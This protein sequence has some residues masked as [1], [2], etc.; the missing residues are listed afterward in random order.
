[1]ADDLDE[2]F[3][4]SEEFIPEPR[5]QELSDESDNDANDEPLENLDDRLPQKRKAIDS[6]TQAQERK[7]HKR[8]NITEILK[9]RKSE[10]AK[11]SYAINEFTKILVDFANKKLSSVEKNDLNLLGDMSEKIHKMILKRKKT[12]RLQVQ[13]QFKKKLAKKIRFGFRANIIF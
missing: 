6:R 8:K 13:L 11:A 12:H 7:R 9:L 5:P 10:L 4:I 1:M 3:E 2:N